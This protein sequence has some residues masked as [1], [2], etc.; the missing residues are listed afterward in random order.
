MAY[1]SYSDMVRWKL[2][3]SVH[4]LCQV[5]KYL[6]LLFQSTGRTLRRRGQDKIANFTIRVP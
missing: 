3:V 1:A 6:L 2:R 5:L 4:T